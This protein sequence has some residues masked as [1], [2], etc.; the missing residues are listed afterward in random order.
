MLFNV[1]Q[2]ITSYIIPGPALY[3]GSGSGSTSGNT[4]TYAPSAAPT[5]RPPSTTGST[6]GSST[7]NIRIGLNSGTSDSWVGVIVSGGGE[8]TVKVEMTDSGSV[9]S[10]TA[11]TDMS[12]SYVYASSSAKIKAPI[13]IRLTSSSGKQVV[14]TNVFTSLSTGGNLID[15]YKTYSSG[16]STPTTV[17]TTP[18]R[19]SVSPNPPTKTKVT[20]YNTASVWWLALTVSGGDTSKVELKDSG[21][22]TSWTAMTLNNWGDS[23]VYTFSPQGDQLVTPDRKS[24]V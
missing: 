22:V 24:V 5:S 1:Y 8:T 13:S 16:G 21:K 23:K 10:W 6:S 18:P 19:P 7:G 17:P 2:G 3:S 4:P 12:Y 20:I 14:L 11:M 9:K 15:T